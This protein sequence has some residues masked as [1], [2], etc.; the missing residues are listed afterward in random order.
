MDRKGSLSI[1]NLTIYTEYTRIG[2]HGSG[3]VSRID[4]ERSEIKYQIFVSHIPK[5]SLN[6]TQRFEPHCPV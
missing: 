2:K 3:L 1:T 4:T 6:S 5:F